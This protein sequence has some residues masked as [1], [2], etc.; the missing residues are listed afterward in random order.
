[1]KRM[2]KKILAL[3]ASLAF[4]ISLL[5]MA[6][7][8]A[9]YGPT[10]S[11][12]VGSEYLIVIKGSNN[13]YYALKNNGGTL[14]A[15]PVTRSNGNATLSSGDDAACIWTVESGRNF[16]FKNN[17]KYL[18]GD[19]SVPSLTNNGTDWKFT[20]NSLRWSDYYGIN[21]NGASFLMTYNQTNNIEFYKMPSGPI[22]VTGLTLPA[23]QSI[24]VGEDYT[25]VPTIT[26]DNATD[27][28]LTWVSDDTSVATVNA[29]GVVHGVSDGTATITATTTDGSGLSAS[30]TVTVSTVQVDSISLS[31]ATQNIGVGATGSITATVLPA[32]AANKNV[33]WSS[34]DDTIATVNG[35]TVTGVAA[36]TVTI[37]ATAQ[38]GS[39]VTGTCTVNV[40][41]LPTYQY[42]NTM[43]AGKK[44]LIV[45]SKADGAAVVL[46]RDN[47]SIA[48]TSVN[49]SG[50]K[51]LLDNANCVWEAATGFKLTNGGYYL[52]R[53]SSNLQISTSTSNTNW[54]WNST[55]E[56]LTNGTYCLRYNTNTFSLLNNGTNS[57]YLFELVEDAVTGVTLDET[58]K[59]ITAGDNFTLRAT[60]SGTGSFDS[61]VTWTSSNDS[62]ATVSSGGVVTGVAPG[63]ATITAT[64]VGTPTKSATC[65]VTVEAP[66]IPV[67][68]FTITPASL[69]ITKGST[70]PIDV[71]VS[72][73][74]ASYDSVTWTSSDSTVATVT[75]TKGNYV[76]NALKAGEA[77][78]TA[79]IG[80]ISGDNSCSITVT[81]EEP[82]IPVGGKTYTLISGAPTSGKNY[83]IASGNSGN[84]V[85]VL[86]NSNGVS[87]K[88][89]ALD[90][91]TITLDDPTCVWA[92]SSTTSSFTLKNG[93]N[94]YLQKNSSN[95][96]SIGSTS[97][98]WNWQYSVPMSGDRALTYNNGFTLTY[99]P[100]EAAI[101]NSKVYFY[102]EDETPAA[103][104]FVGHQLVLSGQIGVRFVMDLSMLSDVSD[105]YMTFE[106]K[107]QDGPV[108]VEVSIE[109]AVYD[110]ASEKYIFTCFVNSL[111]MAEEITATFT[112]GTDQTVENVYSVED[113][114]EY[115]VE[116][117]DA[118]G[119]ENGATVK[120]VKALHDY[121]YYAQ[122]YSSDAHGWTLGEKYASMTANEGAP[123]TASYDYGAVST[124]TNKYKSTLT[125]P[126]GASKAL[127]M[128]LDTETA[129]TLQIKNGTGNF[130]ATFAGKSFTPEGQDGVYRLRVDGIKAAQLGTPAVFDG[131]VEGNLCAL[132]YVRSVVGNTEKSAA[133]RNVVSA[134]YYYYVA[135]MVYRGETP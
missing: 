65:T 101:A 3:L 8:A 97:T 62:I 47:T 113:Y 41:T 43:T 98:D 16:K 81:V 103:P 94:S 45:S 24:G 34:S 114:V 135:T 26:P 111:Q 105:T 49:I 42:T 58:T 116:H 67:E 54:S 112:Y 56:R 91:H 118:F 25:L 46:R 28:T 82:D 124:A 79:T 53:N 51:I 95:N 64:T 52:R 130:S 134:L 80:D 31:P 128:T 120:L 117:P 38:D 36:G 9:T 22:L 123:Y 2:G 37:T 133:L 12:Q 107:G 66:P 14:T 33:T 29:N 69:S 27:K 109:D 126:S 44:Y 132:A 35:G 127:N 60:V 86:S 77:T 129:F 125:I 78:I 106:Y 99:V 18:N 10:E 17:G 40:V 88:S 84:T 73:A 100:Y 1:M 11:P 85:D 61:S 87:K 108:E 55:N 72:P 96:L 74:G 104:A 30:C 71:V 110:S 115:V 131:D 93:T 13:S 83:L 23:A 68:S 6:A 57:I 121:G 59:T 70:S 102:Q 90:N 92:V 20:S 76:V 63:T 21:Y 32:N 119:G 48:T 39:G 89:V 50:G 7:M 5:P 19:Y 122:Q 15:V 4:V 75:G